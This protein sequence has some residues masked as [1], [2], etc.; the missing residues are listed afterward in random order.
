MIVR[1][2]LFAVVGLVFLAA[3]ALFFFFL[4][5]GLNGL[6]ERQAM[7]WFIV[8]G[9]L[10]YTFSTVIGGLLVAGVTKAIGPQVGM[11]IGK[12]ILGMGATLIVQTVLA[13]VAIRIIYY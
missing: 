9:V 10:C 12:G 2:A 8:A 3:S 11:S 5:I 6:S 13:V 4:I 7:P 1:V